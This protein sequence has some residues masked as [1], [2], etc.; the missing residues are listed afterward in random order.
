[1]SEEGLRLKLCKIEALFAGAGIE[2]QKIVHLLE[3]V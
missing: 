2:A 3:A 1:M